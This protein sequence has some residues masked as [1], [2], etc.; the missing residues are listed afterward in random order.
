MNRPRSWKQPWIQVLALAALLLPAVLGSIPGLHTHPLVCSDTDLPAA[1]EGAGGGTECPFCTLSRNPGQVVPGGVPDSC[2][3]EATAVSS[4]GGYIPPSRPVPADT[5]PR[6]P[7][8]Y[9]SNW[10]V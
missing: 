8:V 2:H 5:A 1:S 3:C 7:P 6:A 9:D 4:P 10:N